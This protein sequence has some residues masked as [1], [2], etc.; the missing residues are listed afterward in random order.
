MFTTYV[1][2]S[3]DFNKIYVGFTSDIE[4]RLIAHNHP[5][6]KG[7]TKRYQPWVVIYKENFTEKSS[8]VKRE[9]ELKSS[10]GRAFIWDKINLLK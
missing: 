1:L 7:W 5:K 6:N 9:S 2:Y 3:K 10:R 8:A 4:A